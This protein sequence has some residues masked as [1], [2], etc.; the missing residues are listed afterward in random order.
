MLADH[1]EAQALQHLQV[2]D[3]GFPIRR[4]VQPIGPVS[5]VECAEQEFKLAVKH[6]PLYLV[7]D[8]AADCAE[9]RVAVDDFIA[10]GDCHVVERG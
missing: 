4:Q 2:V 5:L 6:R 10:H 3:H 8:A 1:I 7:D 9:S